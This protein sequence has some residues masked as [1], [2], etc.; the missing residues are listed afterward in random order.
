MAVQAEVVQSE[1]GG[2]PMV[3]TM[4]R[5]AGATWRRGAFL[6]YVPATG[7]EECASPIT[8]GKIAGMA[9]HEVPLSNPK[10][11][12][13]TTAIVIMADEDTIFSVDTESLTLVDTM[14]SNGYQLAKASNGN[15]MLDIVSAAAATNPGIMLALDSRDQPPL[16]LAPDSTPPVRRALIKLNPASRALAAGV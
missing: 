16:H 14:I 6:T 4:K 7:L 10:A 11:D 13:L 3:R 8:T 2:P 9:A 12:D 5:K 1:T 15:W